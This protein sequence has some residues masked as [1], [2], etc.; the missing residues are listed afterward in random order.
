VK[1]GFDNDHLLGKKYSYVILF[2]YQYFYFLYIE[3]VA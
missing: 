3:F 2:M 1:D